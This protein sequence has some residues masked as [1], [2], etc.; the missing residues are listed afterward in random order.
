MPV[1]VLVHSARGMPSYVPVLL[2]YVSPE[3]TQPL[4]GSITLG[5]WAAVCEWPLELP[6][7]TSRYTVAV[8]DVEGTSDVEKEVGAAL[9]ATLPLGA[10]TDALSSAAVP[11]VPKKAWPLYVPEV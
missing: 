3:S 2:V 1:I 11:P 9:G 10:E 7:G 8:H 5:C 6:P 4:A